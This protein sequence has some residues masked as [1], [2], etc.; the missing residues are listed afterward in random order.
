M[1]A[2]ER[3]RRAALASCVRLEPLWQE[4]HGRLQASRPGSQEREQWQ[5]AL[6]RIVAAMEHGERLV[7]ALDGG[8]GRRDRPS[9]A[10]EEPADLRIVS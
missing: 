10:P 4:A 5:L 2:H 7:A 1:D 3:L 8:L 6:D 9:R